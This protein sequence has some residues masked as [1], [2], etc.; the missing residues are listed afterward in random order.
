M[1]WRAAVCILSA[2]SLP[3]TGSCASPAAADNEPPDVAVEPSCPGYQG[4]DRPRLARLVAS[5]TVTPSSYFDNISVPSEAV[6]R[7][8]ADARV[9][10]RAAIPESAMNSTTT[11]AIVWQDAV[12]A[13][14]FWRR[15]FDRNWVQR[16]TPQADG[17]VI[18]EPD[19]Y[20]ASSGSLPR[21]AVEQMEFL[22]AHPCRTHAPPAWPSQTPMQSGETRSCPLDA[23]RYLMRIERSGGAVEHIS[24]P[25]ENDTMTFRLIELVLG[26]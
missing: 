3:L 17:T 11:R 16:S 18:A 14:W 20:P 12:G 1:I 19:P 21:P 2:A 9:V 15:T 5:L 22:L 23:A 6:I 26:R 7:P 24:A 13:W 8:Q 25:C 4:V 10:I